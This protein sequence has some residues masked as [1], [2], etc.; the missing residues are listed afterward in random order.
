MKADDFASVP[1]ELVAHVMAYGELLAA[2]AIKLEIEP[3]DVSFP[4]TPH[5]RGTRGSTCYYYEVVDSVDI[6]LAAEWSKRGHMEDVD[7]RFVLAVPAQFGSPSPEEIQALTRLH[8][9]LDLIMPGQ[10]VHVLNAHDL[11]VNVE[12]PELPANLVAPLAGAY[13]LFEQGHWRKGFEAACIVLQVNARDYLES[14]LSL[15][16][17]SFAEADGTVLRHS[18]KSVGGKPVKKMTLGQLGHAYSRIASPN[19]LESRVSEVIERVNEDRVTVAHFLD[20]DNSD[21]RQAKLRQHVG[22]NVMTVVNGL[23]YLTS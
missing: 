10:L 18:A 19:L 15:S 3:F 14:V 11:A 12:L 16:R 1:E 2:K 5:F 7:T 9:G 22:K 6:G 17:I 20:D 13:E 21:E 8:I 4:K 23:K